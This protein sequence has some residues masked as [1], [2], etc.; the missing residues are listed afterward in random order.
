MGEIFRFQGRRRKPPLRRSR[1]YDLAVP[2]S[3]LL[4]PITIVVAFV[5][6]ISFVTDNGPKKLGIIST[7]ISIVDGDTVRSGGHSYRLVGFD[8]PESQERA[9]CDK[10]R[11]LAEAAS[12]RLR[13][14]ISS[15]EVTLE[16]VSC[17][18]PPGT[19]DTSKCN[20]GRRCAT[21]KVDGKDVGPTLIKEALAHRYVCGETHCPPRQSWCK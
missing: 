18:C 8:T 14:L 9:Q 17:A 2:P 21:L 15:G 5:V 10:E 11:V 1:G 19:E 3:R 4:I 6:I 16:R 20:Y 7:P 13:E 12:Q